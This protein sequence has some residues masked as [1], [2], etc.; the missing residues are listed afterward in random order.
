MSN[1]HNTLTFNH[2]T[3]LSKSK[4]LL[5]ILKIMFSYRQFVHK[6]AWNDHDR[7][8]LKCFSAKINFWVNGI[9]VYCDEQT[10]WFETAALFN[11]IIHGRF[12]VIENGIIL[13]LKIIFVLC[14]TIFLFIGVI[15]TKSWEKSRIFRHGLP[16]DFVK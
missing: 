9:H 13:F 4:Q 15:A 5:F 3:K 11:P 10:K 1:C 16:E 6:S 2:L 14:T 8:T 7:Y 12:T